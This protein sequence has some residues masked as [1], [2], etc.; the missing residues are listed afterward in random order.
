ML[1]VIVGESRVAMWQEKETAANRGCASP[2]VATLIRR[3]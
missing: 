1:A 3:S 2:A